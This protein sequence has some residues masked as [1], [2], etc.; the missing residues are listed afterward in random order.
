VPGPQADLSVTKTDSNGGK[1]GASQNVT[2]TI[3]VTNNGP[4]NVTNGRVTDTWT[5]LAALSNVS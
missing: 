4:S 2:W 5:A 1:V 3:V